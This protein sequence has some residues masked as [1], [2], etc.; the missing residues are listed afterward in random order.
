MC[1]CVCVCVGVCVCVCVSVRVQELRVQD[2]SIGITR[3]TESHVPSEF[4]LMHSKKNMNIINS[5]VG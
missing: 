4:Y 2:V 3:A 5:T 1:V